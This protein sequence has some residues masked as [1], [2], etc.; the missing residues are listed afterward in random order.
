MALAAEL[1]VT[2]QQLQKY[3]RGA[4]RISAGRLYE[5]AHALGLP[6]TFFFDGIKLPGKLA[7]SVTGDSHRTKRVSIGRERR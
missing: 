6:I 7:A 4:N 5:I 2:F 1:G 3:E